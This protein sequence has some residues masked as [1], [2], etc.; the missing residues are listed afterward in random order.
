MNARI[1]LLLAVILLLLAFTI[2]A[3]GKPSDAI[4]VNN[5][6]EVRETS[7]SI[8]QDLVDSLA[9]VAARVVLQYA[10]ELRPVELAALPSSLETLLDQVSARVVVQYANTIRQC[11]LVAMPSALQT[12]LEQVSDRVVIQ[13][14]NTNRQESL[15]YPAALFNDT[16]AP[17][18]SGITAKSEGSGSVTISWTTDEFATST[19]LYG[20]QP[21][22]YSETVSDPLYTR[23]HGIALTDLTPEIMYYY[24]VRSTDRS[25][26][27][28]TSS[29]QIFTRNFVYLPLILRNYTPVRADFTASPTT[30]LAP[31]PVVFTNTSSGIYTS[32]LW[33]FGDGITGT[34][35]SPT[36]TYTAVGVYTVTLTVSGSG[37]TDTLTRPDYIAVI[38]TSPPYT[39]SNP[40]PT[41]GATSQSVDVHLSWTGGDPDGDAVT[42]DVYFEA[43]DDTP[44]VRVSDGQS[45]TLYDPGTLITDTH[46]YWQIVATDEHGATTTGPVWNFGTSFSDAPPMAPSHLQATPIGES[47]IQLDWQDNSADETGF[48]IYDG[49]TM[50]NVASDTISYTA[51]GLAPESYHCFCIRAFNDYGNSAWSDWACATT[52]PY[53]EG[54][55]RGGL[56]GRRL[57]IRAHPQ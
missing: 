23:Q 36:H 11:G 49:V 8:N 29:E 4:I 21:D 30:G 45:N 31:L 19:V 48:T 35:E 46:Y 40:T 9:G 13:Y 39:P 34:L 17:Q 15:A 18:L 28:A 1:A 44:D 52:L 3:A 42:Y 10:N 32:S 41:N 27:T 2:P 53:A 54:I 20:T 16:T 6:D 57:A 50:T 26:N 33:A 55:T 51:G 7:V 22:V 38:T 56:S 14:A 12:L 5:A 43:G 25:G 37:E 47:Q 24:K